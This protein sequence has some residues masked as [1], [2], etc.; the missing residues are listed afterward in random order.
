[1]GKEEKLST[2]VS[3]LGLREFSEKVVRR[4]AVEVVGNL[5]GGV[6]ICEGGDWL[7]ER[8]GQMTSTV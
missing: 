8:R 1:M 6:G 7:S 2:V 4:G 5:R 3:M